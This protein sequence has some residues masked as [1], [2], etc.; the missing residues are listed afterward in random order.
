MMVDRL[1]SAPVTTMSFS[2]SADQAKVLPT[3]LSATSLGVPPA[4]GMIQSRNLFSGF[5]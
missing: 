1:S 4:D 5:R 2:P 3:S